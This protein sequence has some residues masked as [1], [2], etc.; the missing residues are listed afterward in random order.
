MDA[1]LPGLQLETHHIVV[2]LGQP[3][4][5]A[6]C[7]LAVLCCGCEV[8]LIFESDSNFASLLEY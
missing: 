5:S 8:V 4:G 1:H 3:N 6:L 2:P 7:R